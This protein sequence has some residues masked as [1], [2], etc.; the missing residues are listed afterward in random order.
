VV[1]ALADAGAIRPSPPPYGELFALEDAAVTVIAGEARATLLALPGA[2]AG[3]TDSLAAAVIEAEEG[4]AL[5]SYVSKTDR[6]REKLLQLAR[7]HGRVSPDGVLID[8]PLTH[9]LLAAMIGAARETVTAALRALADDGFV[10][11]E[12]RR[13]RVTVAPNSL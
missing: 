3:I 5:L 4:L 1:I 10:R 7:R 9:E 13:Y 11:R 2:A 12:G 6:V 8:V